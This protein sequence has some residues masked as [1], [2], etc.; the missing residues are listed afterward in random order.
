MPLFYSFSYKSNWHSNFSPTF[1]VSSHLRTKALKGIFLSSQRI[2][3]VRLSRANSLN[4]FAKCYNASVN[5]LFFPHFVR[6][7]GLLKRLNSLF[8]L[9]FFLFFFVLKYLTNCVMNLEVEESCA[10]V[11][12]FYVAFNFVLND[13]KASMGEKR[14]IDRRLLIRYVLHWIAEAL[15][16][17]RFMTDC[18]SILAFF[19]TFFLLFIFSGYWEGC[20]PA[21][22]P[23]IKMGK[24]QGD[25]I[26]VELISISFE[27]LKGPESF[28]EPAI[29]II[30]THISSQYYGNRNRLRKLVQKRR[31]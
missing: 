14:D 17:V 1:N 2:N 23:G 16:R 5:S 15:E 20:L 3:I 8:S 19:S 24:K 27:L 31:R 18:Y 29:R 25:D 10:L 26:S 12:N 4:R 11:Q 22:L 28:M 9:F 13:E 6:S 7:S 21:R 30:V